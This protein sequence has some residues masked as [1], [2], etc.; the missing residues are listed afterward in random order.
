MIKYLK[1]VPAS[2]YG[3]S[4]NNEKMHNIIIGDALSGA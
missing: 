2:G 1:N 3:L 4:S